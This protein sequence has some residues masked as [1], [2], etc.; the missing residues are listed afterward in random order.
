MA[1]YFYFRYFS[2][3]SLVEVGVFPGTLIC[4]LM[5]VDWSEVSF[6][7]RSKYRKCILECINGAMTPTELSDGTDLER[8]HISRA[9]A[10]LMDRDLVELL[11]P[12]DKI[13]RLYR[14]TE[15]GEEVRKEL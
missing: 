9:L 3:T 12:E 7:K 15:K 1:S 8:S 11:N 14:I 10:E 2:G 4:F 13:G 5:S 6:V